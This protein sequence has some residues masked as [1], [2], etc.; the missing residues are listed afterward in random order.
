MAIPYLNISTHDQ[1]IKLFIKETSEPQNLSIRQK[2]S[3]FV[4]IKWQQPKY[5]IGVISNYTVE[6]VCLD[7]CDIKYSPLSKVADTLEVEDGYYIYKIDDLLAFWMY[8]F[9]LY[10]ITDVKGN[11]S[12]I[13]VRTSAAGMLNILDSQN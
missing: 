13:R 3:S 8:R 4:V 10:A 6:Y 9:T 11:A 12:E 7:N 5:Q 1:W 2:G